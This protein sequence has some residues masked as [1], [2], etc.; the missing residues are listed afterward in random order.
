MERSDIETSGFSYPLWFDEI[1]PIGF[2]PLKSHEK[3]DVCVIG[4]GIAGLSV[5]YA[6]LK[7]GRSV[8]ILDDGRIGSG[9]TGRTSAHLS[10]ALDDRYAW[11]EKQ[12]GLDSARLAAE[13]HT[14][15]IDWI[16][17]VVREEKIECEFSRVDGFLFLPD[18]GH[19]EEL[20]EEM[21]AAHRVGLTGVEFEDR[22]P[23]RI[24]DTGPCL[25]FPNQAQFH[26]LKY[27][28]GLASAVCRMG[29]RIY[30][31]TH[32]SSFIGGS[33][34]KVE[35]NNGWAVGADAV[36][37]ATNTPVNDR[38]VIHTK[39]AAYRTYVICGLIP[40]GTIPRALY[41]DT[42]D[43]YHYIRI[44]DYKT[45]PRYDVLVVGGEDVKV[46]QPHGGSTPFENL[47]RWTRERF[48]MMEMAVRRWSGQILEPFDGMAF[49]GRNPM[50]NSN[51]YIATGDSGNGL[52]HGTIAGM[53]L[54]DLITGEDNPWADL[55]SPSRS[56]V[57]APG[58]YIKENANVVPQYADWIKRG[59]VKSVTKIPAGTG[60]V[61]RDGLR[62]IAVYRDEKGELHEL[63]AVCPH[64]RCIVRWNGDEKSWDCPCHGSRFTP[65]GRVINGPANVDLKSLK[66]VLTHED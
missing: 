6:L 9:E 59:E 46:G 54:T 57:K 14:A 50:D 23:W 1:E 65:E 62:K 33:P 61:I 28:A 25:K 21:E 35:T 39:Q 53:L 12:L 52:T 13:S 16:E 17:R 55:Y 48:P 15:A 44:S 11:L 38:V 41:W 51:V 29:G 43:P 56:V 7:R 49:I 36:V 30:T 19:I 58:G 18:H 27:L 34:A 32:A 47:E 66:K 22:V 60:M 4:A 37:V 8:V 45:D 40:H 20:D 26:P 63:S 5:A 31:E 64:L 24:F 3:A 42:L 10:N 2:S